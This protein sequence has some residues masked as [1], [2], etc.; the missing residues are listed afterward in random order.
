MICQKVGVSYPHREAQRDGNRT[1]R[2]RARLSH[3]DKELLERFRVERAGK[4][5]CRILIPVSCGN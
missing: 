3:V 4:V 2:N 5:S 1:Y